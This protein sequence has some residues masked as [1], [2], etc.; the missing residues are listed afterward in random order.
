MKQKWHEYCNNFETTLEGCTRVQSWLSSKA[1][2]LTKLLG[3]G[4]MARAA[5]SQVSHRAPPLA[6]LTQFAWSWWHKWR[7]RGRPNPHSSNTV[8]QVLLAWGWIADAPSSMGLGGEHIKC[9]STGGLVLKVELLV[10]LCSGAT[11]MPL[12]RSSDLP[13]IQNPVV[14]SGSF[15][16]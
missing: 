6:R 15:F 12:G 11:P 5:T 2:L 14:L 1:T 13:T 3:A 8:M 7:V 9:G 10:R 4:T 16:P